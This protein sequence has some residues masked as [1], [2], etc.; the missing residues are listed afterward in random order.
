MKCVGVVLVLLLLFWN[1]E[2]TFCLISRSLSHLYGNARELE[3]FIPLPNENFSNQ[4]LMPINTMITFT[5]YRHIRESAYKLMPPYQYIPKVNPN[6]KRIALMFYLK[7]PKEFLRT[8]AKPWKFVKYQDPVVQFRVTVFASWKGILD[9]FEWTRDSLTAHVVDILTFCE[10]SSCKSLPSSC[11]PLPHYSSLNY[12]LNSTCYYEPLELNSLPNEVLYK[13][14]YLG[15]PDVKNYFNP[16]DYIMIAQPN[17]FLTPT[18]FKWDFKDFDCKFGFEKISDPMTVSQYLITIAGTM[19]MRAHHVPILHSWLGR[20]EQSYTMAIHAFSQLHE[21]ISNFRQ[22]EVEISFDGFEN[23][24]FVSNHFIA[25]ATIAWGSRRKNDDPDK[26]P[27]KQENFVIVDHKVSDHKVG[28][29]KVLSWL[30][31]LNGEIEFKKAH[32]EV[33]SWTK[34]RLLKNKIIERLKVKSIIYEESFSE[35]EVKKY[36]ELSLR[37]GIISF[38]LDVMCLQ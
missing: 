1:F 20:P 30:Q 7:R 21:M 28:T 8:T 23:I 2:A 12:N 13:F 36:A 19:R 17:F 35:M 37:E 16:Y 4:T 24:G 27:K 26:S 14:G 15:H 5:D 6:R 18:F 25:A 34:Q 3:S 11:V 9:Y 33:N 38:L 31:E 22:P 29:A 32:D 10:P